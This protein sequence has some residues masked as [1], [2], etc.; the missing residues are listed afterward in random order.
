M[1]T[2][3]KDFSKGIAAIERAVRER[4]EDLDQTI[5][6]ILASNKS[7]DEIAE[8]AKRAGYPVSP[9]TLR[10]WLYG[11]TRWPHNRTLNGVLAALGFKRPIVPIGKATPTTN[12]H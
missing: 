7:L 8:L 6:L 10:N 9:F 1:A 3:N 11:Y 4:D 12:H 5:G 2:T